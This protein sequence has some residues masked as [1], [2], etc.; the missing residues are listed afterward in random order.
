MTN[1]DDAFDRPLSSDGAAPVELLSAYLDDPAALTA[2]DRARVEEALEHDAATQRAFAEL[3]LLTTELQALPDVD[4]PGSFRLSPSDVS[5]VET[6]PSRSR[7]QSTPR[8]IEPIRWAAAAA[9]ILFVIVLSADLVSNSILGG[10]DQASNSS[11]ES[12]SEG[13]GEDARLA[14]ERATEAEDSASSADQAATAPQMETEAEE[15]DQ[16]SAAGVATEASGNVTP[17]P[18]ASGGVVV[19]PTPEAYTFEAPVEATPEA[20][21]VAPESQEAI[22]AESE[23][24]DGQSIWRTIEFSLVVLLAVLIALIIF[25]PKIHRMRRS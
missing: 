25:L 5:T 3:E 12:V 23:S 17:E 4:I 10:P 19:S 15:A 16:E 24:D 14:I 21:L 18:G 8:Y 9:A 13:A 2:E 11:I 22:S 7:A 20:A 1:N 6:S